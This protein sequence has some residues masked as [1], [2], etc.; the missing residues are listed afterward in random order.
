MNDL[1]DEPTDFYDE[2]PLPE[3]AKKR[4]DGT[5]MELGAQLRTRDGR[6][7]GNAYVDNLRDVPELGQVAD[8]ITDAGSC[9]AMIQAEL[10]GGFYPPAY[11][12][13]LDNAR[14]RFKN[15]EFIDEH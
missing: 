1:S 11:V 10:E 8:V 2:Y 5:Y 6:R 4:S 7:F 13:K 12:M 15:K 3:W 9:F 14:R